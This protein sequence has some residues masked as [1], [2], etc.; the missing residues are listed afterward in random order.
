MGCQT[1]SCCEVMNVSVGGVAGGTSGWQDLCVAPW[2]RS[3]QKSLVPC[4]L[5]LEGVQG[6]V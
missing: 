3:K 6:S 4:C 1:F 5:D 2:V